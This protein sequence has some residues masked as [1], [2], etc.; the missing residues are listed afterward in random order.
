MRHLRTRNIRTFPDLFGRDPEETDDS[1]GKGGKSKSKE[2]DDSEDEEED[3][4]S[5]DDEEEEEDDDSD[6]DGKSKSKKD[7]SKLKSALDKER[8]E[9]K[10]LAKEAKELAKFKKEVEDRD[11][12]EADKAAERAETAEEEAEKWRSELFQL[13]VDMAIEK[14]ASK[15]KFKDTDDA[16][17]LIDRD[18]IEIDEE[19]GTFDKKTVEKAVKDLAE[20]KEHLIASDEGEERTPSGSK[21]GGKKKTKEKESGEKTLKSKYP[22][23]GGRR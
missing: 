21:F 19:D 12:S 11:K 2:D 5:E 16:L 14:A 22:A 18:E 6:E 13:K 7:D 3:D 17:R 15:L 20:R 8:R 1:K 23:L 4:D 10:R 9:R